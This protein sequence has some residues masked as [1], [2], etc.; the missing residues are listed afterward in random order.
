MSVRMKKHETLGENVTP[1]A[2]ELHIE[3]DLNTFEYNGR[4]K[5]SVSIKDSTKKI[6]L[7]S[8]ELE[9]KSATVVAGGYGQNAKIK[10][11]KKKERIT[12]EIM[13]AVSGDADNKERYTDV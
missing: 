1:K 11:D 9:L 4:V 2:Y 6:T 5:I 3:P 8:A 7:N 10:A 12:L 13:K